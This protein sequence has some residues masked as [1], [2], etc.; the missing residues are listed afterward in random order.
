MVELEQGIV[1]GSERVGGEMTPRERFARTMH[2]QAVDRLPHMEFGY[3][4]SLKDRWMDEGHLPVDLKRSGNNEIRNDE[5]ESFFGCEQRTGVGPR[6]DAGPPRPIEVV[7]ERE[8]KLIYRDELGILCEEVKEGIRSIPHFIDFPVKDRRSWANFRD[9]FLALDAEWRA[10]SEEEIEEWARRLRHSELPV[11]VNFGSFIG[12]IRNWIGFQNLAFLSYDDP[13][14]LEEMV[15]H[16]TELKLKYL[17]P[18]LDK[19]EFDFAS[20]WEDICFNSGPLLSPK[21]FKEVIMPH[22]VPVI[23]LLRQHGIDVIFTDCDGNI[24]ALVPLW[25][26]VGLNCMFPYE[27]N[28]GN[29]I[30]E[31]RREYGRDLLFLGGFDKFALFNSKEAVLAE[32]RKLEPLMA[33]GGFIPHIDHRCPDGVS[34]E[35]YQYYIREK[36]HFLGMPQ[37]EI[38]TVPGLIVS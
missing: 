21:V 16:V 33:D 27:V 14:L 31:N 17:P 36:C 11:G 2:Y 10:R 9:E 19:I 7:E 3:W 12:R 13:A 18:L 32:F 24:Q 25:L 5:V 38:E 6:I 22:M 34:F 29:D 20:G 8:G 4:D 26:G 35:M 30:L 28:A 37:D 23:K 15:A 1:V